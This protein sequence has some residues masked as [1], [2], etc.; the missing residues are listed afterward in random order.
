ML[1]TSRPD[2]DKLLKDIKDSESI[3]KNGKLKIYIGMCAGVGKTFSMLQDVSQAMGR[4]IKVLIGYIE[5]HNRAETEFLLFHLPQLPRK[6]I[7]Y[8]GLELEEPD[9]D[10]IIR[11][12]PDLVVIDELAHTNAPGGRHKK[13][14]QDV[15]ELLNNGI[16]VYTALNVQHLES[17]AEIISQILGVPISETVPDTILYLA[18]EVEVVDISPDELLSRLAEGKV[19]TK[20][21]SKQAVDN[22][23]RRGN[24]IALREAMLR[25]TADRIDRM[26]R[27][28]MVKENI[29]GP[30]KSAQ[31]ILIAISPSPASSTLIRWARKVAYTMDASL[32]AVYIETSKP[33]NEKQN[34]HLNNNLQLARELGAEVIVSSGDD[35]VKSII[36]IAKRE[37]VTNIL[38]GKPKNESFLK[39]IFSKNLLNHILKESGDIDIFIINEKTVQKE[40]Q[41]KGSNFINFNSKFSE[42]LIS[43]FIILLASIICFIFRSVLG[44]QTVALILLLIVSILPL[45][46]GRGPVLMAA[47]LSP[48]V[49]NYFFVPPYLTLFISKN[50]D[51][52]LFIS[53]ITVAT[54]S[55]ILTSRLRI[56]RA[57]LKER[58][59][60]TFS[61]FKLADALSKSLNIDEVINASIQ[62]INKNFSSESHIFLANDFGNL[63]NADGFLSEKEFAIVQWTFKNS[64]KAGRFTDTLS[65][66][67]HTYFPL[68]G[69]RGIYGVLE[70]KFQSDFNY[71]AQNDSL[72]KNFIWQIS[73]AIERE[74]LNDIAKKLHFLE[75]SENL[76]KNLFNSISHELKTPLAAIISALDILRHHIQDNNSSLRNN[77][78]E[79]INISVNRL[80]K[81][82]ENLLDMTR[83]ESGK[84][85]LNLEWCDIRDIISSI[86][87]ELKTNGIEFIYNNDIINCVYE[88]TSKIIKIHIDSDLPLLNVDFILIKEA[89]KNILFNAIIYTPDK[90]NIDITATLN[91]KNINIAIS[92]NGPGIPN[93]EIS[94]IFE[95]FHR[96]EP[97][98]TGGTGLGL[99]IAKGFIEIH[100]GTITAKNK[101]SGGVTFTITLPKKAGKN[102]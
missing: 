28:Y 60:I 96:G 68:V 16:S 6:K 45:I 10:E 34:L 97:H 59:Q 94:L 77:L 58:E 27:D 33:L 66:S 74:V 23:F 24:L 40:K 51:F 70:V 85:S 63:S 83:I 52:L 91:N 2:P 38:I 1:D 56:S 55:S 47:V 78:Y 42:Y 25:V 43:S 95:K 31:R 87:S 8:K 4:G 100:N 80:N 22:F 81:L 62:N 84:V 53:F 75:E 35:I 39:K 3:K 12:K 82:I 18:D 61:L 41:K 72:L 69:S 50:E 5:T 99:S 44:Y 29:K 37:N 19:Y 21:K 11:L 30:W 98:K 36:D 20:D 65:Q 15:I 48:L 102:I 79:E 101:E 14:Y 26:M 71:N 90:A 54:V 9:I 57:V 13:R 76:Y 7:N 49:W 92:D 17:R 64:Q 67:E 73:S 89:I 32:L 86:I 88:N 93:D 46:F